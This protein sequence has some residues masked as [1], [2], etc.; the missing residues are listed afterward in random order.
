MAE[1]EVPRITKIWARNFKSIESLELELSPLTV[2]VGPNGSGKSN[3]ADIPVFIADAFR[4]GVDSALAARGRA[5]VRRSTGPVTIGARF[6][7]R[8]GDTVEYEFSLD[9]DLAGNHKVLQEQLN[10]DFNSISEKLV[11]VL[12][13]GRLIQPSIPE[14]ARGQ[15]LDGFFS[16]PE[17][18]LGYMAPQ[19][20]L[21]LTF[22]FAEHTDEPT[23]ERT[24]AVAALAF[25]SAWVRLALRETMRFH[26]SP[27]VVRHPQPISETHPLRES[28][29]NL[30]SVIREMSKERPEDF[31]QLLSGL[32]HIV[33][34]VEDISVQSVGSYQYLNFTHK[35]DDRGIAKELGAFQESDGTLRVLGILTVLYQKIP[36]LHYPPNIKLPSLQVIEEPETA[37]HPGALAYLAELMHDVAEERMPL[38]VTTHSP[39]FLDMVP[40]DCIRAVEMTDAGTVA[41]PIAE[42]QREA[43]RKKLFTPGELHRAEGLQITR[44]YV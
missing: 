8:S 41:A 39:D 30:A 12:R 29:E 44:K 40:A 26:I 11:V 42:Y 17:S 23:N 34:G 9:F 22:H 2:L 3:I 15:F 14:E 19:F 6:D 13:N 31:S 16:V 4:N 5:A 35:L 7:L 33:P 10:L 1:K 38:I 37:V 18:S 28:G 32:G 25:L 20:E 43:I 36:E 24:Q 27:E 21:W